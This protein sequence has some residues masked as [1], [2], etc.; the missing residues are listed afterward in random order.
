MVSGCSARWPRK[1]RL[2]W[3]EADFAQTCR[4]LYESGRAY[5]DE[6]LFNGEYYEHRIEPPQ[7]SGPQHCGWVWARR[8]WLIQIT[9]LGSGCLVD[10]LVGQFFAHVCGLGYL[11]KRAHVRQTLRSIRKYNHRKKL[12]DHF[13]CMRSYAL[14]DESA[15]LMASYPHE[16]PANPFPYFTEVMTG[17]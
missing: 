10:Q 13:N 15:L 5:I 11:T 14:G 17:F 6:Q 1:W 8:N 9:K 3:G 2:I 4:R 12:T 16:R 7:K